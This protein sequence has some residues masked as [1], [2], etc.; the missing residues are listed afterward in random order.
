MKTKSM[1]ALLLTCA[2]A[3]P[4]FGQQKLFNWVHDNDEELR[5]DPSFYQGTRIYNPGMQG[6]HIRFDLQSQQ[7]VTIAVTQLADWNNKI[8]HPEAPG[9]L[10]YWCVREHEVSTTYDCDLPPSQDSMVLVIHDER[11]FSRAVYSG[12]GVAFGMRGAAQQFVS[13]NDI[14]ISYY[15]WGCVENC[16]PP[17][18]RTMRLVKE[19]YELTPILKVYSALTPEYDGEQI[20]IKLKSP[21]PMMVAV[22]PTS[23]ANGLDDKPEMVEA[24]LAKGSCMQRGVQSLNTGCKFSRNDGP[25]SLVIMPEQGVS[26]PA[27]K[28]AQIELYVSKCYANC[29]VDGKK[30]R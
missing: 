4:L 10:Q 20:S 24:A 18:F 6:M 7:P 15:R 22:L 8:Q 3:G 14:V 12:I 17:E 21:V 16:Y 19:K 27:R 23:I 2:L 25:Q 26:I 29:L 1:L 11:E 28:K 30:V 13:P 5:L 9:H